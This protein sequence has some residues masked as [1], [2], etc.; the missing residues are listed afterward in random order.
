MQDIITEQLKAAEAEA[1]APQ[2]ATDSQQ[3]SGFITI[4]DPSAKKPIPW[5]Y[6]DPNTGKVA[7]TVFYLRQIP[8]DTNKVFRERHT[9]KEWK[10]GQQRTTI[11]Q[12]GYGHD[13]IDYAIVDWS[14][15]YAL[16]DKGNRTSVPCDRKYK[17]VLPEKVQA[18]I[19]RLCL[20]KE[21]AEALTGK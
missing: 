19:I 4:L 12:D 9:D 1:Q 20:G 7:D 6:R 14:D 17:L 16:D 18:E 3:S 15:L 8:D 10:N 21:L 5:Q 11:N 2:S 13:L